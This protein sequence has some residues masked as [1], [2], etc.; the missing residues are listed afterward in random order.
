MDCKNENFLPLGM[1]ENAS[2]LFYDRNDCVFYFAVV[3]SLDVLVK[4]EMG[5][6]L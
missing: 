5:F 4:R 3:Q 1:K 6:L 2:G